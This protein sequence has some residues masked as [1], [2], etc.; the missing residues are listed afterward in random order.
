MS[1][2]S[3]AVIIKYHRLGGFNNR[4]LFFFT[5]LEAGNPR[6]SFQAISFLVKDSFWLEA[7]SRV[8]SSLGLISC[9][10]EESSVVAL[11]IRTLI[12]SDQGPT[13]MTSFNRNYLHQGVRAS[14][15]EFQGGTKSQQ[16][17]GKREGVTR[18]GVLKQVALKQAFGE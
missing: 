1:Q 15:Y 18:E 11:L 8:L 9:G 3:L 7:T 4:I 14:T 13:L 5:V 12:L 6:S 17:I 16:Q 10:G 2:S